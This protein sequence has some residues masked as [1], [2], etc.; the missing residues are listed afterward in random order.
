MAW[1]SGLRQRKNGLVAFSDPMVVGTVGFPARACASAH[2]CLARSAALFGSRVSA[3]RRFFSVYS[4]PQYT[5]VASGN[6]ISFANDASIMPA[7]PSKSRPQPP[8]NNV[9]PVNTVRS[10]TK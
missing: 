3:N 8:T 6:A 5:A 2:S 4:C 7:S 1:S 10:R 9:S